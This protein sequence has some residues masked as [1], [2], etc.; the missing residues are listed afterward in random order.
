M[1]YENMLSLILFDPIKVHRAAIQN[2][3]SVSNL[4]ITMEVVTVSGSKR[5]RNI[6]LN[7][8]LVHSNN[9]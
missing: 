6:L 4:I 9:Y 1:Q 2:A 8:I 7:I 3:V 5:R